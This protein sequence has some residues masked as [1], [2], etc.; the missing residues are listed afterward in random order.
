MRKLQHLASCVTSSLS[1][2]FM[3]DFRV[4]RIGPLWSSQKTIIIMT[5]IMT[6]AMSE[7]QVSLKQNETKG[8]ALTEAAIPCLSDAKTTGNTLLLS[9]N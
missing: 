1:Q 6:L 7:Q 8:S 2:S 9:Y 3:T 4:S 5:V